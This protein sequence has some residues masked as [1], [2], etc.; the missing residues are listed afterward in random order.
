VLP[1]HS[2][3]I[4]IALL[5][6]G[7]IGLACTAKPPTAATPLPAPSPAS[8][9][10]NVCPAAI[11][12]VDVDAV[13]SGGFES[14]SIEVAVHLFAQAKLEELEAKARELERMNDD[15]EKQ[16]STLSV[17]EQQ[18]RYDAIQA[19]DQELKADFAE[20]QRE[21]DELSVRLTNEARDRVRA[22]VREDG[23]ALG[24][25]AVALVVDAAGA[26]LWALSGCDAEAK[27]SGAIV[28]LTAKTTREYERLHGAGTKL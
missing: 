2:I 8:S 23:R 20:D 17:A 13:V 28:D 15:F 6:M 11:G 1:R 27:A 22:F 14:R 5:A 10:A 9:N 24:S 16:K 26:R 19:K 3:A 4:A 25:G 12:S 21:V 7:E 18:R